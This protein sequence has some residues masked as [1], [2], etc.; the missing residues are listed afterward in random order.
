MVEATFDKILN[1]HF[2][3]WKN[4]Q[5]KKGIDNLYALF[6]SFLDAESYLNVL[7]K[8]L[9]IDRIGIISIDK[10]YFSASFDYPS[11]K[12]S[13]YEKD[14][15]LGSVDLH[16][17]TN[18][19]GVCSLSNLSKYGYDN[20]LTHYDKTMFIALHIARLIGYSKVYYTDVIF[21]GTNSPLTERVSKYFLYNEK[22][23]VLENP[24]WS[25]VDETLSHRTHYNIA[26]LKH[27]MQFTLKD[28]FEI[29]EKNIK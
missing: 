22:N 23:K 4:F 14:K 16:V 25:I 1:T 11:I 28:H 21:R 29:L 17:I 12:I 19:C 18:C 9:N 3:S 6:S 20:S 2:K 26:L 24:L 27:D 13:I 7:C 8:K 15:M 5:N 10:S